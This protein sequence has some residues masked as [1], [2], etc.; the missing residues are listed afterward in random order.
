MTY[1]HHKWSNTPFGLEARFPVGRSWFKTLFE[2][3]TDTL[4]QSLMGYDEGADRFLYE[5]FSPLPWKERNRLYQ[6]VSQLREVSVLFNYGLKGEGVSLQALGVMQSA[7]REF[8]LHHRNRFD[9][10]S[11]TTSPYVS[12]VHAK[13]TNRMIEEA[14]AFFPELTEMVFDNPQDGTVRHFIM[15]REL[16]LDLFG[17]ERLTEAEGGAVT[18]AFTTLTPMTKDHLRLFQKVLAGA[19]ETGSANLIFLM[20]DRDF[21]GDSGSLKQKASS[22]RAI[23]EMRQL[24]LCADAGVKSIY[25]AMMYLYTDLHYKTVS[26]IC[27]SDQV[28]QMEE[29]FTNNNGK[30]TEKGFFK[31]EQFKVVSF[32][33]RNP[34]KGESAQKARNALTDGDFAKYI[35]ASQMPYFGQLKNLFNTLRYELKGALGMG[36]V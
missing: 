12:K 30:K 10:M 27:G 35:K 7:L 28:Q 16:C 36:G 4:A 29:F 25:D 23:P 21:A 13:L 6:E 20:A 32:G 18:V 34:D 17:G 31:F 33:D 15:E 5:T 26:V 11:F 1:R 8:S 2:M 24:N 19:Q 14:I 22:I 9:I 3:N